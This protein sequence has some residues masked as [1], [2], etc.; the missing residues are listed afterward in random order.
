MLSLPPT[1]TISRSGDR[2]VRNRRRQDPDAAAAPAFDPG[3]IEEAAGPEPVLQRM[4]PR[5]PGRRKS[6]RVQAEAEEGPATTRAARP[7]APLVAQL[8]A[9]ALNV[10]QTRARR[11]GTLEEATALYARK[12][13]KYKRSRGEA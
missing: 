6:D 11:R 4:K 9:T 8:I 2:R 10:E 3:R 12:A 1:N 5:N 13:E 7:H